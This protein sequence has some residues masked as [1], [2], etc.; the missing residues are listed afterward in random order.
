ML[1]RQ[2]IWETLDS[3]QTVLFQLHDIDDI[4]SEAL[5]RSLVSKSHFDPDCLQYEPAAIRRNGEKSVRFY[6]W[7]ERLLDL[8]AEYE[9]PTP[10]GWIEV[11]LEQ[12]SGARYVMLATLVGVMFA[13]M[14]GI[15][16]LAVGSLQAWLAY[17]AWK[18]PVRQN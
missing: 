17:Q 4:R 15:A 16:G 3:V 7:G 18:H 11:W 1:P 10:R 13:L 8:Y 14:L 12:K 5:L 9:D 2:L 6:Y